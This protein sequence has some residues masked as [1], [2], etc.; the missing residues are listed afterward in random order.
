MKTRVQ[1]VIAFR[2][3]IQPAHSDQLTRLTDFGLSQSSNPTRLV[4]VNGTL[5]FF[6]P[7][8]SGYRSELWRSDG[9]AAGTVSVKRELPGIWNTT[10]VANVNGTL[11]FG[12]HDGTGAQ[13]TSRNELWKSDGTEA[14]TVRVE[15]FQVATNYWNLSEFLNVNGTLFFNAADASHGYEFWKSDGTASGRVLVKDI[16]PG[17]GDSLRSF[18]PF[19]YA[20]GALFFPAGDGLHGIQLWKY[21]PDFVNERPVLKIARNGGKLVLSWPASFSGLSLESSTDLSSSPSWS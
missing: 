11:F 6:V 3:S 15:E 14:G 8:D 17:V 9:T 21:V 16:H 20:N 18:N 10:P 2:L 4:H 7:T 13:A 12:T 19:L 1:L 5:F